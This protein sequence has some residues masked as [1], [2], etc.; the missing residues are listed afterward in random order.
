[1]SLDYDIKLGDIYPNLRGV[2]LDI[3]DM[4]FPVRIYNTLK[5]CE[6]HTLQTLLNYSCN[7]ILE[8]KEAAFRKDGLIDQIIY[9]L[10]NL[11]SNSECI[12]D[13]GI[14]TK[15]GGTKQ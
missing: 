6:I 11:D 3:E 14:E 5:R 4:D 1:M 10:D 9:K 15:L 12:V 13:I 2:G 7:E 8:H